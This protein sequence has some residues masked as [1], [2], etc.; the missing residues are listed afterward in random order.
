[1][2]LRDRLKVGMSVTLTRGLTAYHSGFT[3][4]PGTP[5]FVSATRVPC[6]YHGSG[7]PGDEFA[8]VDVLL[9]LADLDDT[10]IS[11]L[12]GVALYRP[13]QIPDGWVESVF[14]QPLLRT[15]EGDYTMFRVAAGYTD[16]TV[17][18]DHPLAAALR[19]DLADKPLRDEK[20]Y[21]PFLYPWLRG[22]THAQALDHLAALST[23]VPLMKSS[24]PLS[25]V[26]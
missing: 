13:G 22:L 8:C 6:V 16:M 2:K 21:G 26:T 11:Q 17:R 7:M 5:G 19:A 15:G 1:M 10:Q 23:G 14:A 9:R 3:V 25:Q 18:A 20:A 12:R 24:V 4:P